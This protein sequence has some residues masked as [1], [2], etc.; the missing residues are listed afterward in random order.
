MTGVCF[1][2]Q[3][4]VTPAR[5]IPLSQQSESWAKY[6][7]SPRF[8]CLH[9]F[10]WGH[11]VQDCPRK[12]A[13][14]PAVVDPCIKN[15]AYTLKKSN[16]VSHPC[17]SEVEVEEEEPFIASIQGTPDNDS[18]VLLDSGATHHVSGDLSLF[19]DIKKINL[20]L[21]VASAKKHRVEG[22]GLI[23]LECPS[24]SLFLTEA[25]YCPDIPGT[26]VY[27][28]KFMK[29]DGR[30]EFGNGVFYLHQRSCIYPCL[31]YHDRWFL[32]TYTTLSCNAIVENSDRTATLFHRRLAHTSLR[33]IRKLQ[34]LQCVDGLPQFVLHQ[35]V[36][37]C[38]ACSMAKSQHIPLSS[39]SRGLVENP[40]NVIVAD[41]MGPFPMSFDKRLYAMLVQDH[42]S[43]L[44]TV[45]PLRSKS[46]AGACLIDW[47]KKFNNLTKY[48]VKRVRTDNAGE[49]LA[50]SVKRFFEESGITHKTIVPYEHHQAGKI[51][52]TNRTIAEAARSMLIDSGVDVSLWPYAFRQAV[53]VFNC[54]VHGMAVKTP[55]EL[56]TGRKPSLDVLRVFGCKGYVHNLTHKKD[57]SP[58]AR[59]LVHLGV[60]ENSKGWVFWDAMSKQVVRSASVVFDEDGAGTSRTPSTHSIEISNLFDPSML[61]EIAYQDEAFDATATICSLH[62]NSPSTYNEAMASSDRHEWE[63]AMKKELGSLRDMDVWEAAGDDNLKQVLG[64]RWVYAVKRNQQGDITRYK[65]R[66]V[67]QGHRQIKGLNFD[68]TFA[69]TPTFN[70]LRCLLTVAAALGWEI[71]TFD[72][73]T[74]YLHSKLDE[75]IY[76]KMPQGATNL[77]RVLKL[78]K[79]LYGLKQAGRCWWNH[80]REV[81]KK[82]GFRSN[83]EDQST[84]T[85]NQADGKAVL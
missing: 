27:L 61:H 25:L 71:Q 50:N 44:V 42:F 74:A 12:K 6:H 43:S 60:A 75:S 20:T 49:F 65:A 13:S 22:R 45:Y 19:T 14:L 7:L 82:I 32:K 64:C 53:W 15:P 85:Y 1:N 34:K 78:K 26:V 56:V 67:V 10:E 41:L 37:I 68:E 70:S 46:E 17:V 29:N 33:T 8:P 62:T 39:L 80:L 55:Y 63:E 79:A 11:W 4:P 18:L 36:K 23:R 47:I 24:G 30:V 57:L 16:V 9:C 76:V 48:N 73:T 84:Y 58:K 81:L 51:E 69:P 72:V 52:R 2:P 28:G 66:L 40:G 77:P 31:L 35:D 54:I 21:S 38:R 5:Q 3:K 59:E 83:P